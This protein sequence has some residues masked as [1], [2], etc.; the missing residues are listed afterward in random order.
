MFK[1]KKKKKYIKLCPKCN[2]I[3]V[4]ITH[5]GSLSGLVALGLPTKYVCKECGF[6]SP[7][8]PEIERERVWKNVKKQT[9]TRVR[10]KNPKLTRKRKR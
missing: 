9:K 7:F 4:K 1:R 8:F 3:N 5:Q 6:A 2:S 10:K